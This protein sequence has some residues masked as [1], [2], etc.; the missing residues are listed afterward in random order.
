MEKHSKLETFRS[1]LQAPDR[2]RWHPWAP[3]TVLVLALGFAFAAGLSLGLA[4]QSLEERRHRLANGFMVR[5]IIAS[6]GG[7]ARGMNVAA[8]LID[9]PVLDYYVTKQNGL[10]PLEAAINWVERQRY[11]WHDLRYEA[12]LRK[13]AEFRVQEMGGQA[14]LWSVTTGIC[15]DIAGVNVDFV[16]RHRTTALAYSALL[17]RTIKPEDLAPLASN[18]RCGTPAQ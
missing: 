18:Y 16:E 9:Q 8:A 14:R 3:L 4:N 13:L 17:G 6:A 5:E 7:Q 11:S 10:P 15:A 12:T 2:L 1:Y